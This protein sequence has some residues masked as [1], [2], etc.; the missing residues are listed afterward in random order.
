MTAVPS[1]GPAGEAPLAGELALVTGAG[2]GIGRA[3]AVE[4]AAAGARVALLARSFAQLDETAKMIKD[5]GGVAGVFPADA[6]DP[7]Q[8]AS[9]AAQ[10]A[11]D[12]GPV[13]VLI[14]NA[15]VVA[16]L[17]PTVS[18]PMAEWVAAF[19][20]NV[21]AVFQ[22][23]TTL[24]PPMLARGWGRIVNVSSG[25]AASPGPMTGMNAYATTKAA[26][27]AHSLNL[28]GEVAGSGVTVN[29]YR[30]GTVD[31]AMQSWIRAQPPEDIGVPLHQRFQGFYETGALIT[32]E[33][34]A[35]ALMSHLTGD[36][37]GQVWKAA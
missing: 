2:R 14:N 23:T 29:I 30:P 17:G 20:V 7:G 18:V 16:P 25:V 8:L 5:Q 26:L 34:S 36:E 32:P 21:T 33:Q 35:R 24:L 28:A 13:S 10:I 37:T 3:V 4:L 9:A 31:T 1:R 12:L 19:A 6:G 22:L 11:A 27:E 15:A